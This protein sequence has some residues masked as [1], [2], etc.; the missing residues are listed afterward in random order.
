[1]TLHRKKA[2]D[3][4]VFDIMETQFPVSSSEPNKKEL[5]TA[6]VYLLSIKKGVEKEFLSRANLE[7]SKYVILS[8]DKMMH[9][10]FIKRRSHI[11]F[12][13]FIYV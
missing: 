13:I 11:A 12:L 7:Q 9:T 5:R 4:F 6:L 10:E 8:A 1:M 3:L 2:I